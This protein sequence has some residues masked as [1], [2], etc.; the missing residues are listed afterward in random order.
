VAGTCIFCGG[1]F[2]PGRPRRPEHVFPRWLRRLFRGDIYAHRIA[3]PDGTTAHAWPTRGPDIV[4]TRVCG[5]CNHGWLSAIET[6]AKPYLTTMIQGRGREFD[7]AGDSARYVACWAHKTALTLASSDKANPIVPDEH[8]AE[9][10]E[11]RDALPRVQV[12][13][14]LCS[15]GTSVWGQCRSYQ[16][17]SDSDD[18]VPKGYGA[19]LLVGHLVL[20]VIRLEVDGG[21]RIE[22]QGLPG[23]VLLPIWPITTKTRW[24]PRAKITLQGVDQLADAITPAAVVRRP[25]AS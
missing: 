25:G 7:P 6:R 13:F 19:T 24:P 12:W 1:E 15:H 5:P 14:T 22:I 4:T 20:H 18:A 23:E 17:K 21:E 8:Y 11:A 3:E 9:L 16:Y 10:Y 2:G